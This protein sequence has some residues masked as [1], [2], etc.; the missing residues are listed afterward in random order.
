MTVLVCM[1]ALV[2]LSTLPAVQLPLKNT[3]SQKTLSQF[4]KDIVLELG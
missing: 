1:Q 4:I 3:F 2:A